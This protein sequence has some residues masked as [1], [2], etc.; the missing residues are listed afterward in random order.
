MPLVL[1]ISL[2][3]PASADL[4]IASYTAF[5]TTSTVVVKT[6]SGIFYGVI[7]LATQIT[8]IT[9]YDN[10]ALS[11]QP[12]YIN[13]PTINVNTAY[14]ALGQPIKFTIGLTCAIATS[15]VAPG[16]LVLWN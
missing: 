14:Y 1:I 10:T 4:P 13:T 9:C 5:T 7:P 16:F 11:G 15:I 12:I 2:M 6:T 8:V 3:A